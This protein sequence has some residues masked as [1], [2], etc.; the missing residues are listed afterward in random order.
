VSGR[1]WVNAHG[2]LATSADDAA[3]GLSC[4]SLASLIC[5]L[6]TRCLDDAASLSDVIVYL[7]R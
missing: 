6:M 2:M 5:N 4:L 1:L 3:L 7:R